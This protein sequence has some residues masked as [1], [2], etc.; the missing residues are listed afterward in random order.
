MT[1][2]K[3][4]LEQYLK[5]IETFD[6]DSA[7]DGQVLHAYLI[8]LTNYM[9]RANYLMAEHGRQFRLEKK[10][11]YEGLKDWSKMMGEK[12]APSLAKDFIDSQCSETGYLYDL[13]ERLSRLCSHVID[14][15]RTIISS[16]KSERQFAQ[17]S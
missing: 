5:E 9:A 3:T 10:K 11:A 13:A 1:D 6:K 4:E 7:Q 15:I 17:Y 8:T 12:F 16:L 14:A 2:V